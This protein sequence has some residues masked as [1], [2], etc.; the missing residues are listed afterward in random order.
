ML[1]TLEC[2]GRDREDKDDYKLR[3]E[4]A[5]CFSNTVNRIEY[6]HNSSFLEHGGSP[7]KAVRTAFVYAAD[8]YLKAAGSLAKLKAA[9][10]GEMAAMGI[11]EK[12]AAAIAAYFAGKTGKKGN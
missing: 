9:S 6:Y 7:D 5:F 8:K 1:W 2:S 10:V 4:V 12:D 11:P 3:A